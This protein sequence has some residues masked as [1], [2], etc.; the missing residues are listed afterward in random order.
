MARGLCFVCAV[1]GHSGR[2]ISN[3]DRSFH[4]CFRFIG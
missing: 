1:M 2:L 4:L 3:M